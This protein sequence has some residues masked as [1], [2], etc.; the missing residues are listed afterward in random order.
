MASYTELSGLSGGV[1]A[2]VPVRFPKSP[3]PAVVSLDNVSAVLRD[4][5]FVKDHVTGEGRDL[6][7]LCSTLTWLAKAAERAL[8]PHSER[9]IRGWLSL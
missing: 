9:V 4:A 2:S 6:F 3:Q 8:T 5:A 7:W 1:A